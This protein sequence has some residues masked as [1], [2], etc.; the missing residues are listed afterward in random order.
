MKK[1]GNVRSTCN[2]QRS[3]DATIIPLLPLPFIDE[4]LDSFGGSK[5]F[6]VL[7]LASGF[8]QAAIE[9]GSISLTAVCTKTGLYEWLRVPMGTSGSPGSF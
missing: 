9:P 6:S 5:V 8:V 2:Y 4:L 1:G 3:N 7:G